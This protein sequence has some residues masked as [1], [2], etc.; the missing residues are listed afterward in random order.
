MS[1]SGGSHEPPEEDSLRWQTMQQTLNLGNAFSVARAC[2]RE[3]WRGAD[4]ATDEVIKQAL[5]SAGVSTK[6]ISAL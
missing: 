3:G 2:Q 1:R 5:H 4:G 6:A